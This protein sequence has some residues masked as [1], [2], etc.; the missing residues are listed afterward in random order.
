[1]GVSLGQI[2]FLLMLSSLGSML[3]CFLTGLLLDKI[4]RYRYLILAGEQSVRI[5]D[6]LILLYTAYHHQAPW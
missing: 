3:G 2:S 6:D 1:M 4:P 5:E